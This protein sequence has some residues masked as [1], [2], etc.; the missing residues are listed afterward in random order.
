MTMEKGLGYVASARNRT[1]E[2]IA[3]GDVPALEGNSMIRNASQY[4]YRVRPNPPPPYDLARY[5]NSPEPPRTLVRSS[6]GGWEIAEGTLSRAEAGRRM[7]EGWPD[8]F[9]AAFQRVIDEYPA[10]QQ[11][12]PLTGVGTTG[13]LI[14]EL[15]PLFRDNLAEFSKQPIDAPVIIFQRNAPPRWPNPWP[16]MKLSWFAEPTSCELLITDLILQILLAKQLR[17][18]YTI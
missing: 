14:G 11:V 7:V 3:S 12:V 16:A 2:A 17:E 8:H 4:Y 5:A 6:S 1:A 15:D 18:I 9:P 10:A 13:R